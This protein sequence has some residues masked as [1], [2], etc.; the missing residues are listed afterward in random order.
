MRVTCP[1]HDITA[2]SILSECYTFKWAKVAQEDPAKDGT[3]RSFW[4]RQIAYNEARRRRRRRRSRRRNL[5]Q[6]DQRS[7]ANIT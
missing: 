4:K 7:E 3:T 5:S 2:Q 1:F 6:K